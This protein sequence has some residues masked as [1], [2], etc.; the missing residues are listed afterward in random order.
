MIRP[1]FGESIEGLWQEIKVATG[2][3]S[4]SKWRFDPEEESYLGH[5]LVVGEVSFNALGL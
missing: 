3:E 1:R 5:G 2:L 4:W